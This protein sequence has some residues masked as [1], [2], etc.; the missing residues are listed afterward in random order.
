MNQD[1]KGQSVDTFQPRAIR[2]LYDI[3]FQYRM[4]YFALSHLLMV[5]TL[6]TLKAGIMV[7]HIT[8]RI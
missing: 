3:I 6:Y 4:L 1:I 5:L 2:K 7:S 8:R